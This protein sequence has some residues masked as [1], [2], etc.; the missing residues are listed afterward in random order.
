VK[1]LTSDVT[2]VEN[3]LKPLRLIVGFYWQPL[4]AALLRKDMS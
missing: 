2:V 3:I 1:Q 4:D